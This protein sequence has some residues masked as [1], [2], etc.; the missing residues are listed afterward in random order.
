MS[1]ASYLLCAQTYAIYFNASQ[2]KQPQWVKKQTLRENI[3]GQ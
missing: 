3:I 1:T 2:K